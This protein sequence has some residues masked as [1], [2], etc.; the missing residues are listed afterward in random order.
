MNITVI[1]DDKTAATTLADLLQSLGHTVNVSLSPRSALTGFNQGL[2]DV[3]FLD[4]NMP[5][6]N[7]IEVC[8]YLRR[9]V[10]TSNLPIIVISAN[11]EPFHINAARSAGANFYIVKPASVDD[12][13]KALAF[14]EPLIRQKQA[15]YSQ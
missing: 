12:I 10:R 9:D 11:D 6:V 15:K 3:V 7:G 2:P 14:V 5:G 8:R 1:D 4:I 13:E